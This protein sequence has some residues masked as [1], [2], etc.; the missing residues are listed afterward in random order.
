MQGV[1]GSN[2]LCSISLFDFTTQLIR[3]V[4]TLKQAAFLS[5]LTQTH[6]Y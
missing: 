2:P 5:A 3:R 1:S 6:G 4:F